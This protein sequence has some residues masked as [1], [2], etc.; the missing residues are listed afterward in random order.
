MLGTIP[1][2]LFSTALIIFRT[3]IS[4]LVGAEFEPPETNDKTSLSTFESVKMPVSVE[5][6]LSPAQ[7]LTVAEL[8]AGKVN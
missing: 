8:A 5:V 7:Y 4:K 3:L 1:V 6:W 2:P